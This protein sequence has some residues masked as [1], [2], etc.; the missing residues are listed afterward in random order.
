MKGFDEAWREIAFAQ[1]DD[2]LG[3][4]LQKWFDLPEEQREQMMRESRER[5]A[6][7]AREARER[8]ERFLRAAFLDVIINDGRDV[9][10][11]IAQE[12]VRKKL[13]FE[14]KPPGAGRPAGDLPPF[15][16]RAASWQLDHPNATLGQLVRIAGPA[17]PGGRKCVSK[18]ALSHWRHDPRYLEFLDMM[19]TLDADY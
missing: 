5:T 15:V 7:V 18:A 17:R 1:D 13:P 3:R 9:A 11:A 4:A 14:Q 2:Q 6:E 19:E 12:I 8:R 10:L 16:Q